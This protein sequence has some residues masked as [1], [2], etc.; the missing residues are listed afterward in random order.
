MMRRYLKNLG[1]SITGVLAILLLVPFVITWILV[2][3]VLGADFHDN[4]A[5]LEELLGA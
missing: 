3:G 1:M 4:V 2:M 5:E